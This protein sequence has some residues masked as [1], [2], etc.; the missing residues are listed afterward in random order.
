MC[1]LGCAPFKRRTHEI[2]LMNADGTGVTNP[3]SRPPGSSSAI[4]G[5]ECGGYGVRPTLDQP[6]STARVWPVTIAA[7]SEA[8]KRRAS[9][10]SSG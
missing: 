9:A 1:S 6:P 5:R 4:A 10:T 8:R 2:Y 7:S 3:S